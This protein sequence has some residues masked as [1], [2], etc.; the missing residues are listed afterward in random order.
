MNDVGNTNDI[1]SNNIINSDKSFYNGNQ[2]V[3]L[4]KWN[5]NILSC[6]LARCAACIDALCRDQIIWKNSLKSTNSSCVRSVR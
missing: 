3:G 1:T 6:Q 2:F 4:S 5:R